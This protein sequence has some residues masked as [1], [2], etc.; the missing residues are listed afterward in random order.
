MFFQIGPS[1]SSDA[2][3]VKVEFKVR[4]N[5]HGIVEIDSAKVSIAYYINAEPLKAF[6]TLSLIVFGFRY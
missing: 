4:L 6:L 3:K 2:G 5:G 1:E